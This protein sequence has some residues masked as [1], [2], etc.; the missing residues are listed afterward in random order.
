VAV[1][2]PVCGGAAKL[3]KLL[4]KF[5]VRADGLAGVCSE[6]ISPF[7][8][9]SHTSVVG[10]QASLIYKVPAKHRPLLVGDNKAGTM[11]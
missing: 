5:E 2:G 8:N 4:W 10:W 3:E 1:L 11:A 7:V 9:L 6:A